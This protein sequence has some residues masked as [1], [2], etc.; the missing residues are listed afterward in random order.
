MLVDKLCCH[1]ET[2]VSRDGNTPFSNCL[3]SL[4][5]LLAGTVGKCVDDALMLA[6]QLIMIVL[7]PLFF[8]A[9]YNSLSLYRLSIH[10]PDC[11]S[12]KYPWWLSPFLASLTLPVTSRLQPTIHPNVAMSWDLNDDLFDYGGSLR[13]LLPQIRGMIWNWFIFTK[14]I[15]YGISTTNRKPIG[16]I[17][18]NC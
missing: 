12:K 16:G 17:W 13:S 3:V 11:L 2:L 8:L 1:D 18:G 6:C 5:S 4:P 10:P 9:M 14:W 15:D 7:M